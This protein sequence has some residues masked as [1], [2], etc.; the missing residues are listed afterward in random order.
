VPTADADYRAIRQLVQQINDAWRSGETADLNRYFHTDMVIVSP[1]FQALTRGRVA[2]VRS[3]E[4]FVRN[5]VIHEYSESE[6]TIDVWGD[7]AVATYGWKMAYEQKGTVSRE[8]GHD[9]FVFAREPDGW[10]A[11]WRMLTFGPQD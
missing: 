11:V 4:D 6:P 1:G 5:A 10:R 8:Q 9:Q 7:T 3:Y 2:C